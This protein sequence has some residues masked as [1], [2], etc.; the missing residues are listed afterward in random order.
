MEKRTK[1][2]VKILG[3]DY[4]FLTDATDTAQIEETIKHL[5]TVVSET[6]K[7]NPYISNYLAMILSCLNLSEERLEL[8][9]TIALLEQKLE[10]I[11]QGIYPEVG[12]TPAHPAQPEE[13]MVVEAENF[14]KIELYENEINRLSEEVNRAN[15]IIAGYKTRLSESRG[16]YEKMKKEYTQME[17][18][19]LES[20]IEVIKLRK[21]LIE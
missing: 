17:E 21:K 9:Q 12:L 11:K 4:S 14:Q 20:Q 19:L 7:N 3:T 10:E 2:N 8:E 15:A 6:K 18:R 13:E 5:E 16:E 1:V